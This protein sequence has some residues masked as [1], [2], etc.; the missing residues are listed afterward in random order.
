MCNL[1]RLISG[2]KSSV[3]LRQF[4]TSPTSPSSLVHDPVPSPP[5]TP[6][7]RRRWLWLLILLLLLSG[8]GLLWYFL[9]RNNS[10]ATTAPSQKV[11]VTLQ[12]VETGDFEDSSDFV[13]AL[14]AQQRVTL[15]PEIPGRIVQILVKSGQFVNADTPIM[16]L[17]PD[18]NREQLNAATAN[19]N[20]QKA[21]L[22]NAEAALRTT[23]A[24]L[25][26]AQER[27]QS[28]NAELQRQIAEV[29]L[30]QAEFERA[31]SLVRQG[32]QSRQSLDVQT[33]NLKSS[34]AARDL[35]QKDL[36]A[37]TAT[38]QAS[39]QEVEAARANLDR[40][41]ATLSQAQAQARVESENL[42]DTR[43]IAPVAGVMGD[44]NLKLGDYV[45]VGQELTTITLNHALELRFSVP[46]EKAIGLRLG[47]PVEVRLDKQGEPLARGKISFIAPEVDTN[48]QIVVAKATFP[49]PD[50]KLRSAQFVRARVIWD[51]SREVLIPTV[52]VSRIGNQAFVFVAETTKDPKSGENQQVAKQKPIRLGQIQGNNYHVLEGLKAGESI[53]TSGILN[54]SDGALIS[55]ESN[56]S[57]TS[58]E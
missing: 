17:R 31:Q 45:N 14:E 46:L 48:S 23:Q 6:Q 51:R 8:G 25:T 29:A 5:E 58:Q 7:T 20:V 1:K 33:R 54:L 39:L 49:N 26:E 27:R 38:V 55:P 9:G 19:I 10:D 41:N 52:A 36:N 47:L 35:A 4:M 43:V 16:Q 34:I 30:Q 18:R 3:F 13:G 15:R 28:A 21:A 50:G 53:I 40:E 12:K 24:R 22:A 57:S 37:A 32:V 42:K 56:N 44:I 2:I 11:P